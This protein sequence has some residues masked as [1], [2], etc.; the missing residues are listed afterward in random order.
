MSS[1]YAQLKLHVNEELN[2][3]TS[4]PVYTILFHEVIRF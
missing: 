1:S 3:A 2:P 4:V